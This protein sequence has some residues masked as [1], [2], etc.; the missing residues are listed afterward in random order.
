MLSDLDE[1]PAKRVIESEVT[2]TSSDIDSTLENVEKEK[3]VTEDFKKGELNNEELN[4][5][6]EGR[7]KRL[8]LNRANLTSMETKDLEEENMQISKSDE[9]EFLNNV[10]KDENKS[11]TNSELNKENEKEISQQDGNKLDEVLLL[12]DE[13]FE[14][15]TDS[16]VVEEDIL[17]DIDDLLNY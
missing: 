3:Q 17:K 11:E 13:D 2:S 15:S 12:E 1:V 9:K 8:K 7:S 16:N 14:N 10:Q 5:S 6:R 4:K